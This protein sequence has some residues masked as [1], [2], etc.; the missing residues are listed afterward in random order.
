[1]TKQTV[2]KQSEKRT[3]NIEYQLTQIQMESNKISD[4]VSEITENVKE[5]I[6]LRL[7]LLMLKITEKATKL[8]S[9]L[10]ISIVFFILI[11]LI[12]FFI[13]LAFIFWFKENIGPG[14]TACLITAVFYLIVGWVI[15]MMRTKLFVNPL[16]DQLSKT[17]LEEEHE[18]E[19]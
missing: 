6:Q 5:Y 10:L 18:H 19:I 3:S 1:V 12:T 9:Y 17:F 2:T 16:L 13:S 4:G 14:W 7:D 8:L 11:I 15:F